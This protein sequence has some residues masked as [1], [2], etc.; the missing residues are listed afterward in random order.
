MQYNRQPCVIRYRSCVASKVS[1]L[2]DLLS[3]HHVTTSGTR[4][5]FSVV[6]DI[7][8]FSSFDLIFGF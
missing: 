1:L 2:V 6:V 7:S 4:L 8:Y 5:L 3:A